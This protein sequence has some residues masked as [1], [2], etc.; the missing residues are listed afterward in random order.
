MIINLVLLA[1]CVGLVILAG[2]VFDM[3]KKEIAR[4]VEAER[5]MN[6]IILEREEEMLY[7]MRSRDEDNIPDDE[8]WIARNNGMPDYR[9]IPKEWRGKQ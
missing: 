2:V 1:A 5:K 8:E 9:N 7:D 3:Y 4:R 6:Q